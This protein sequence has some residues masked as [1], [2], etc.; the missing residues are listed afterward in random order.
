MNKK[1]GDV[2]LIGAGIMSATLGILL[3]ELDPGIKIIIFERLDLAA[4]E[5]SDAW[6]NAGTGHSAFCEMNYTP[7]NSDG[8]IETHKAVNVAESFEISR[9]FWCYLVKKQV[10]PNPEDF[11]RSI[12]HMC[13]VSGKHNVNYLKKRFNAMRA[14]SLFEGM[15]FSED[16]S[17]IAEWIL[18]S[19][20]PYRAARGSLAPARRYHAA[21]WSCT[22]ILRSARSLRSR[23]ALARRSTACST[24]LSTVSGAGGAALA[25]GL[26]S[27]S[28]S[29]GSSGVR[30]RADSDASS[31]E[32]RQGERA[33]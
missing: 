28:A 3:K 9:Q 7:E 21:P 10:L 27:P 18:R 2:V 22:P 25:M 15:E 33:P 19:A 11:I 30:A 24:A 13:F 32:G 1:A 31:S 4:S 12:P 16:S 6:N 23:D 26:A 14:I 8:T 17:N 29:R 20:V 5:S